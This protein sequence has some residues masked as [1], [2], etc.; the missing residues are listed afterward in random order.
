[1]AQIFSLWPVL[2]AQTTYTSKRRHKNI[3]KTSFETYYMSIRYVKD[4]KRSSK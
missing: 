2:I 4:I 1:M 3:I